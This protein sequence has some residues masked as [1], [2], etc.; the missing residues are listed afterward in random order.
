MIGF[1]VAA[2]ATILGLRGG[3]FGCALLG[4]VAMAA[5]PPRVLAAPAPPRLLILGDSIGA[6]YGLPADQSFPARLAADLAARGHPVIL[7]DD[8]VSGDTSAGGVARLDDALARHPDIVLV[9]LG[10]NDA[11]RAIDPKITRANL[12]RIIAGLTA[13]HVGIL[14]LGMKA[15]A[16]WGLDYQRRFDAIYPE[17]AEKFHVA[18][19]PFL[20]AGVALD[21]KLNQPDLLHPNAAGAA[22]IA[23]RILLYVLPL[24]GVGARAR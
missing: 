2:M 13:A 5:M 17:L 12:D 24:L 14:L 20:L 10:A 9:E 7:I 23:R 11:L 1:R 3:A 8:S 6:G 15:P 18:L 19:Y 22:L 21:P 4:A 16:N